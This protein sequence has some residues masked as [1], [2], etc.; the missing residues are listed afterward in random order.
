MPSILRFYKDSFEMT[1][2][3][4]NKLSSFGKF[5]EPKF[6]EVIDGELVIS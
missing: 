2:E 1:D 5:E 3:I 6:I 4:I